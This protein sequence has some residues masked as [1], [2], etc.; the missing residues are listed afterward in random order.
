M[1]SIKV[2]NNTRI[3][4]FA[5]SQLHT[6]FCHTLYSYV[7]RRRNITYNHKTELWSR[8]LHVR[9]HLF[10]HH[11][12]V[13]QLTCFSFFLDDIVLGEDCSINIVSIK[14]CLK[15]CLFGWGFCRQVSQILLCPQESLRSSPLQ[16]VYP[17]PPL[18]GVQEPPVSTLFAEL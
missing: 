12:T 13:F 17:P 3:N 7:E 15:K 1:N 2:S 5:Y 18:Q 14:V 8:I 10:F 4:Y 16:V 9:V 11:L 6:Y